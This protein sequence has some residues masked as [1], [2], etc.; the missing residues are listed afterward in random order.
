M[1]RFDE[2]GD[3]AP[4]SAP[5][6]KGYQDPNAALDSLISGLNK[7]ASI[8]DE[9]IQ[10][11]DQ[12]EQLGVSGSGNTITVP[13]NLILPQKIS[14]SRRPQGLASS[15]I[16]AVIG[17]TSAVRKNSDNS[18]TIDRKKVAKAQKQSALQK[19]RPSLKDTAVAGAKR[20]GGLMTNKTVSMQ[21]AKDFSGVNTG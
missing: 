13:A 7:L 14:F 5:H 15:E 2:E 12:W 3:T 16:E 10:R 21:G 18:F 20:L 8:Y 19:Q 9:L 6:I 4:A 11:Q 1:V 17:N